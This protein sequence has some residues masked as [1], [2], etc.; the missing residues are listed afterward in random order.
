VVPATTRSTFL[1][2]GFVSWQPLGLNLAKAGHGL[3]VVRQTV[4][5]VDSVL[6]MFAVERSE[7]RQEMIPELAGRSRGRGAVD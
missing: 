4:G 7:P 6:S 1:E 2:L 5:E 3:D